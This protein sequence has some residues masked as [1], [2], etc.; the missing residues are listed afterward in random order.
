MKGLNNSQLNRKSKLTDAI[1][2]EKLEPSNPRQAEYIKAIEE[3]SMVLCIGVL[4]S[5]KTFIPS[6][7]AA[8]MLKDKKIDKIVVARPTEGRGVSV[9]FF[10]G[11]KDDKLSGWC[12]PVTDTLKRCLGLSFYDYCLKV[13]KIELLALEQVKGKSWDDTFIIVDQAEDLMPEVAKSLVTR[14]GIRSQMVITG[15]FAQQDIQ[16]YSGLQYLLKVSEY[17]SYPPVLI[18]FDNWEYCVRSDEARDWG[19]AFERY[20]SECH[21]N[22]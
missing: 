2:T 1:D 11:T 8:V 22:A 7:M 13:E 10:K 16:N 15:D 12:S 5:A 9:G 17:M 14:I 4:G 3:N 21:P 18:N 6:K 20:D 19:M